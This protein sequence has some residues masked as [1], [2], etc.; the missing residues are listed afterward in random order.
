MREM[1]NLPFQTPNP[2]PRSL[3]GLS[4]ALGEAYEQIGTIQRRLGTT[5]EQS[6]DLEAARNLLHRYANAL[7]G[8][9]SLRAL[10]QSEAPSC[11]TPGNNPSLG[12][13][14][15]MRQT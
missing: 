10:G 15:V 8:Y 14:S 11:M 6:G 3:I 2:L 5:D 12:N 1:N 13:A 9:S 4:G 7:T